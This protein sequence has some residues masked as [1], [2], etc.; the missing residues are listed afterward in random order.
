MLNKL[1]HEACQKIVEYFKSN[2]ITPYYLANRL[3]MNNKHLNLVFEG[4]QPFT[5]NELDHIFDISE[6]ILEILLDANSP[7]ATNDIDTVDSIDELDFDDT[8]NQSQEKETITLK[9]LLDTIIS[10]HSNIIKE[11]ITT[12]EDIQAAIVAHPEISETIIDFYT[13]Y[14]SSIK[15]KIDSSILEAIEIINE[16]ETEIFDIKYSST[17]LISPNAPISHQ[18]SDD[19][20]LLLKDQ[21]YTTC[22]LAKIIEKTIAETDW[23]FRNL[24]HMNLDDIQKIDINTEINTISIIEKYIT[25][26]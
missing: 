20:I 22:K 26:K 1:P 24:T 17:D 25:S 19:I 5:Q 15:H 14:R 6:Y 7:S 23:L 16:I 9:H 3:K 2:H 21:G 10:Q 18:I 4:K 12:L 13:K 11:N 8:P